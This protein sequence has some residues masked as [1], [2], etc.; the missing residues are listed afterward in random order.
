MQTPSSIYSKYKIMP[1]LREHQLRVASVAKM[2]CDSISTPID[3][4]GVVVSCLFHDM[5]NI[6]KFDLNYFPDFLEPEGF[7]YWQKVKDEFIE[8][9]GNEEHIATEKICREIGLS[10]T[11]LGYLDAIGF[12][13]IKRILESDSLEKKICLYSDQRVGPYGVISLDERLVDG[14]KRYEGRKDKAIVSEQ[15]EELAQALKEL[16]SQ[17]FSFSKIKPESISDEKIEP[18]ISIFADMEVGKN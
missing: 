10:D 18:N 4:G 12:S 7:E 13:R 11:E 6:I 16:E 1:N 5:G 3:S 17:I 8:K 2:I 14:R 9:Y 15:F